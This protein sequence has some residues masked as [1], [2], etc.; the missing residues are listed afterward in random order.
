MKKDD[1]VLAIDVGLRNFS[2]CVMRRTKN[3]NKNFEYT[4]NEWCN[5][6]ILAEKFCSNNHI[7]SF[8]VTEFPITV[9]VDILLTFLRKVFPPPRVRHDFDYIVIESQP[10]IFQKSTKISEIGTATIAYF[11]SCCIPSELCC[12]KFPV[13]DLIGPQT[14]FDGGMFLWY[15]SSRILS[16][17]SRESQQ[18]PRRKMSYVKRKQYGVLL[19]KEIME[20]ESVVIEESFKDEF[21]S[22]SKKDDL[23]DSFLLAAVALRSL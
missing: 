10:R 15:D 16:D 22:C 5:T 2:Y 8:S 20:K 21:R 19:C 11:R 4:I 7:E 14:K 3:K 23:A 9:L 6:N 18:G 12:H 1:T 13:I 17:F